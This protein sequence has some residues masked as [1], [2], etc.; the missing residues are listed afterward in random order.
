[1]T[2]ELR[3]VIPFEYKVTLDEGD[4][5]KNWL[6]V[7]GIFQRADAKN[8]N[9][10]IYPRKVLEGQVN[11][12]RIQESLKKRSMVG[13]LDHP[14]DGKTSLN[15]LAHVVTGLRMDENGDTWGKAMILNTP[16]GLR[17]KEY[18]RAG[19]LVGISSRGAGSVR[20]VNGAQV[21]QEDFVL[22][23]FD[24]VVTPSTFGAYPKPTTESL[25]TL[26]TTTEGT[27][28][29]D[30]YD[31]NY[32][33]AA[34]GE[35]PNKVEPK[36]LTHDG[37]HPP[38]AA[39]TPT[40][41]DAHRASFPGSASIPDAGAAATVDG[42][43]KHPAHDPGHTATEMCPFGEHGCGLPATHC[44]CL[45]C[46]GN[47]TNESEDGSEPM[48]NAQKGDQTKFIESL[49]RTGRVQ[50]RVASAD[51]ASSA[52]LI[53]AL[54]SKLREFAATATAMPVAENTELQSQLDAALAENEQ[55]KS[56]IADIQARVRAAEK[57]NESADQ[58]RT[59]ITTAIATL[60]SK[61]SDAADW[62]DYLEE[63]TSVAQVEERHKKMKRLVLREGNEELPKP[64][65]STKLTEGVVNVPGIGLFKRA[66]SSIGTTRGKRGGDR[67]A[68][69]GA[70][71]PLT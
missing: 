22:N 65:A 29:D 52:R 30:N 25:P 35:V 21:V 2:A 46:F 1:M 49:I 11:S 67:T 66:S 59:A 5:E 4:G 36:V 43:G 20:P 42:E 3:D 34:K 16:E 58:T 69:R 14:E 6:E 39:A 41:A 56:T 10:R 47:T 24:F 44:K 62:Q 60:V 17:L 13:E 68:D 32:G 57:V 64:G 26:A 50:E 71:S 27:E 15:R 53:T 45:S 18:F 55:L 48:E 28:A 8:A 37:G 9:G 19:I 31:V 33:Y 51:R 54:V 23:T 40:P 70:W 61:D 7:E 38:T 12:E 63:S